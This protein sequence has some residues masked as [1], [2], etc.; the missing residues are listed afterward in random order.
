MT[1]FR[2]VNTYAPAILGQLP[3]VSAFWLTAASSKVV[4]NGKKN[5]NHQATPVQVDHTVQRHIILTFY[6]RIH[7][8]GWLHPQ[9][10]LHFW[11]KWFLVLCENKVLYHLY[12]NF[13]MD[14][15]GRGLWVTV[16]IVAWASC[17]LSMW[18]KGVTW[19]ASVRPVRLTTVQGAWHLQNG[20]LKS[21]QKLVAPH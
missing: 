20:V 5:G 3:R 14:H 6:H 16:S 10:A 13:F 18:C 19:L 11:V 15:K 9:Q 2:W 12:P 21:W 8:L 1:I 17:T 7:Q 4:R